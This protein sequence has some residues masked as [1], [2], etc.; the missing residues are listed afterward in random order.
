MQPEMVE[1]A[2]AAELVQDWNV[3]ASHGIGAK[4]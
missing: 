1:R 4:F 3:T 2:V